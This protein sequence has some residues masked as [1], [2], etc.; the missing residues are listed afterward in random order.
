MSGTYAVQD[1]LLLQGVIVFANVF[2]FIYL[3]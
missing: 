2:L 3:M 1:L